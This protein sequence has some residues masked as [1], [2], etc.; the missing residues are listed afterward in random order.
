MRSCWWAERAN[1][2]V[3]SLGDV[4]ADNPSTS[5]NHDEISRFYDRIGSKTLLDDTARYGCESVPPFLAAP[6]R[7]ID[8][9]I[10]QLRRVGKSS[11]L[12]LCCG[13]G[14]YSVYAAKLGFD[15]VGIDISAVSIAAATHLAEVQQ[16]SDRCRFVV[17]DAL[18]SLNQETFDVIFIGSA[19]YY[20]DLHAAL[21]FV[22]AHLKADGEFICIETYGDNPIMSVYR[23]LRARVRGDRDAPTLTR[24]LGERQIAQLRRAFPTSHVR[25]YGFLTLVGLVLV[26]LPIVGQRYEA[27]ARKIDRLLLNRF[28][29]H[30]WSFNFVFHG[31]RAVDEP[32][33]DP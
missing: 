21:D 32:D 3:K 12:D 13:P 24:L 28:G 17:G 6:Y 31:N 25:Y 19:L 27:I 20:L 16:V 5:L 18:T 7:Q 33:L 29:F 1:S 4:A 15:V 11:F 23:R 9:I 10:Q 30:R 26:P 14:A 8:A 2:A 22:R